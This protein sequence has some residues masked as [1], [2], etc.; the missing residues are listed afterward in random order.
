MLCCIYTLGQLAHVLLED[1]LV[2]TSH[3][4][5]GVL[6]LQSHITKSTFLMWGPRIKFQL[7]S[8]CSGCL[9]LLRHLSG[10]WLYIFK[11]LYFIEI[12]VHR[13]KNTCSHLGEVRI[14]RWRIWRTWTLEGWDCRFHED[15]NIISIP[16][17][18]CYNTPFVWI[19]PVSSI[20]MMEHHLN[21][22]SLCFSLSVGLRTM[23]LR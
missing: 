1:S 14:R 23:F 10:S 11:I 2:S 21:P 20:G 6:V 13:R 16:T 15:I 4:T 17:K 8:L 22:S 18:S 5:I 7:S 3:L 12:R 19:F 9:Y